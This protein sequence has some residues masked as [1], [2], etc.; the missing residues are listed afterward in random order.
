MNERTDRISWKELFIQIAKSVALRSQDPHTQV[1]AVIVKD[2]RILSIGYNGCPSNF[3]YEFD[4]LTPDKYLYCVHAE[5]NAL[6]NAAHAG[7][8]VDGADVYVTMSPCHDCIK[9]LIQ[10]GVKNVY[11]INEYT[12]FNI[13]KIIAENTGKIKLYKVE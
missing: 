4:W 13:T 6:A 10:A 9:L 8:N 3:N 2:N 5:A 11:Y 12:D 7:A 1:G